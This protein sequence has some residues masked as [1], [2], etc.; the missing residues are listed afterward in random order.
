VYGKK[1]I[2]A[3]SFTGQTKWQEHPYSMKTLGDYMY[4]QGLNN[5]V[6]HR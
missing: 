3:E 6:F 1:I 4:T 5:Y 2:G